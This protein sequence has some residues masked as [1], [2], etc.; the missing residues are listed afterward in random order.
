MARKI[1]RVYLESV[2]VQ[3]N[4]APP[5]WNGDQPH[6]LMVA[7]LRYPRSGA[8]SVASTKRIKLKSG[9]AFVA[10]TGSPVWDSL[11]F[12]EEVDD[13][14]EL[15]IKL[16]YHRDPSKLENVLK[17]IFG[18]A[19]NVLGGFLETT[20]TLGLIIGGA[21][22]EVADEANK[23]SGPDSLV[24]GRTDPLPIC[25]NDGF[26]RP[27]ALGI[28]NPSE[29]KISYFPPSSTEPQSYTIPKGNGELKLRF[30][31]RAL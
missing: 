13:E 30:E 11:I 25:V 15:R 10:A 6:N 3:S 21:I 27:V 8:P 4:G 19:A 7:T 1:L 31:W 24:I 18:G 26:E 23:P 29:K 20:G 28:V 14:T 17:E 5:G 9:V 2:L 12:K 22:G 16:L